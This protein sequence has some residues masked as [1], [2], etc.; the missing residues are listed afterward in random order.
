M[1]EQ[2]IEKLEASIRRHRQVALV[3][4][5]ALAFVTL[6]GGSTTDVAVLRLLRTSIRAAKLLPPSEMPVER[7]YLLP[8]AVGHLPEGVYSTHF[9]RYQI[10]LAKRLVSSGT[11]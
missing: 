1:I 7:R 11:Y 3:L 5:A 9:L 2:R 10:A 4:G 8:E 6:H